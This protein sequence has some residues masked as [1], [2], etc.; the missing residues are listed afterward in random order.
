VLSILYRE[1]SRQWKGGRML[2]FSHRGYH[3]SAAANTYDAFAQAVA[4]G[5]DGIE[6]DVRL[7]ADGQLILCHDRLTPDGCAIENVTYSELFVHLRYEAP[8]LEQALRQWPDVWWNLEIKIPAA[9]EPTI[10]LLHRF[11]RPRGY[12]LTSFWHPVAEQAAR[13]LAVDC[14]VLVAHRPFATVSA[15]LGWWPEHSRV[16]TVVW[17]YEVLDPELLAETATRGIRNFVYGPETAQEHRRC[18]DLRLDGVITDHPEFLL[19]R[20]ESSTEQSTRAQK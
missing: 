17:D 6:T 2:I 3:A 5:V 14:G 10:A 18:I 15:P 7:S 11:P 1:I 16:N 20:G 8:L 4:L 9:L 13:R 12:L 19:H